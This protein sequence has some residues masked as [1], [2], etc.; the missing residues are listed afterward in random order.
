VSLL[1]VSYRRDDTGRVTGRLSDRL[2]D[3]YGADSIFID[4]DSI[5]AGVD[6]R[7][8]IHTVLEKTDVL[9]AIVGTNGW[10]PPRT[11]A[12]LANF[13]DKRR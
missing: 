8:H 1:D 11:L 10:V 12:P 7:H 4:I 2:I 5:P 3:R 9:L 13:A 6:F